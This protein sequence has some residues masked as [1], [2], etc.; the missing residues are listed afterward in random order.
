[1]GK[2]LARQVASRGRGLVTVAVA[3]ARTVVLGRALAGIRPFQAIIHPHSAPCLGA[4]P[5]GG[6]LPATRGLH[7]SAA[8]RM[9]EVVMNVPR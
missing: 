4:I 7:M 3:P 1:M 2:P 9:A 6:S 5:T 8:L